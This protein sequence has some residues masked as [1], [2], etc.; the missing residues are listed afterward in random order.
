[1]PKDRPIRAAL[2]ARVSTIDQSLENQ[3]PAL[4]NYVKA[5]GWKKT[6]E[7]TDQA[8]GA[9]NK[10]PGLEQIL[11]LARA[12]EIDAIVVYRL[13]RFGRSTRELI[14]AWAE[15]DELGVRF[16]SLTEQMDFGSPAGKVMFSVI[17]AM[18]EFERDLIR[19][20]VR[21]G[22]ERARANGI[23]VGRPL[24][25]PVT[26][27]RKRRRRGESPTAIALELGISRASVYRATTGGD[28]PSKHRT[29]RSR[30]RRGRRMAT[31]P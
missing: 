23:H 11:R 26:E 9:S 4:R 16:V 27:I 3:L 22:M 8:S 28:S 2:Y 5:R 12:R 31:T 24:T 13:D 7:L 17:S 15:L 19:D 29:V 21:R 1:M 25:L 14:N 10:R 6:Y 20:R 30:T 18:A